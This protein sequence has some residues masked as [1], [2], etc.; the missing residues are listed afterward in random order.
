MYINFSKI[1]LKNIKNKILLGS[2]DTTS[3]FKSQT[4]QGCKSISI[5]RYAYYIL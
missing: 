5:H 1:Y 2:R 3:I 4:F